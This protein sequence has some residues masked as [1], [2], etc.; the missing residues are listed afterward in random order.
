MMTVGGG[1]E[2]GVGLF[3]GF[4]DRFQACPN[5]SIKRPLSPSYKISEPDQ[6][7]WTAHLLVALNLLPDFEF[8][9]NLMAVSEKTCPTLLLAP[10]NPPTSPEKGGIMK[11]GCPRDLGLVSLAGISQ[12][13]SASI[14]INE[15][16][17]KER[18]KYLRIQNKY[19][20]VDVTL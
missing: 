15:H 10:Q 20:I 13:Q 4:V 16:Q 11:N 7:I 17:F 5:K 6:H 9:S 19:V 12:K 8:L 3:L 1:G 18:I 2:V 14:S